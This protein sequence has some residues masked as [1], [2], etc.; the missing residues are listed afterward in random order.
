MKGKA[1]SHNWKTRI[2]LAGLALLLSGCMSRDY[3]EVYD[4]PEASWESGQAVVFTFRPLPDATPPA[5]GDWIDILVQHRPD[6]TYADLLLEV[7]GVTPDK[8]FWLD[9]IAVPLTERIT[10]PTRREAAD[11]FRWSGR[12]FSNHYEVVRRYREGIRYRRAAAD[13]NEYAVSIRQI[14]GQSRLEGIYSIGIIASG[15]RS[16]RL[17]Q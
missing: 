15:C 16:S 6:F 13:S 12:R 3:L 7:K 4:F 17:P 14:S 2:G 8:Q 1:I 9:T 5:E 11:E 10:N